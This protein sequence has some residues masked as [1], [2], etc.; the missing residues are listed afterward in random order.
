MRFHT[1]VESYL[2][3]QKASTKTSTFRSQ[4]SRVRLYID[5]FL[6]DDDLPLPLEREIAFKGWLNE[7]EFSQGYKRTIFT[8][9]A[10]IVNY[11]RNNLGLENAR[12]KVRGFRKPRLI[13]TIWDFKQFEEFRM[14]VRK[15]TEKAF[16]DLLYYGGLRR[17][18]AMALTPED[19]EGDGEIRITKTYSRNKVTEPKT[20][21]STRKLKL[22]EDVYKELET[23]AQATAQG[24]RLFQDL[25]YST[26]K[27]RLDQ[28]SKREGLERPRLHDLRHSH[29]TMLLYEGFTPQGIA[30]RVGHRDTNTLLNTY[31]SYLPKEEDDIARKLEKEFVRS[32]WTG[33]Q[34]PRHRL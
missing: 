15:P 28:I 21:D 30:H 23:L 4:E 17:G 12:V 33:R 24:H 6:K 8:T 20:E 19:L 18:E 11:A 29:I 10:Q 27:R 31:A 3:Y 1:A 13:Y 5:L 26:M 2:A 25:S 16:F 22:P 7:Q 9:Y 14:A 32:Q 34:R